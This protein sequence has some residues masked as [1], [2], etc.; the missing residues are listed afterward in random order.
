MVWCLSFDKIRFSFSIFMRSVILIFDN[1]CFIWFMILLRRQKGLLALSSH[2]HEIDFLI[3]PTH[4]CTMSQSKKKI[5]SNL[6]KF[7]RNFYKLFVVAWK[8]KA[9]LLD[10]PLFPPT[11]IF[12][13]FFQYLKLFKFSCSILTILTNA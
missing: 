7:N 4:F 3:Y 5:I 13:N 2:L 1:F 9:N 6:T 8:I 12:C 11:T 10:Y